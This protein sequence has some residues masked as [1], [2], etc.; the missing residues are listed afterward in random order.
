MLLQFFNVKWYGEIEY[1]N[2]AIKVALL[3]AYLVTGLVW[4]FNGISTA[5]VPGPGLSN[6]ANGLSFQGGFSGLFA[7]GYA[8]YSFGGTELVALTAGETKKPYK[9]IPAAAKMTFYRIVILMMMCV[10]VIGL[11]VNANNPDL[12]S[13][14]NNS[15]VAGKLSYFKTSSLECICGN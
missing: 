15:D 3:I 11:T 1:W 6:F 13:A 5:S 10:F 9:Y 12:I 7:G 2:S 4:A 14:S 8:F